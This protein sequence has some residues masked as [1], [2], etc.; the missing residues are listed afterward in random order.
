MDI[1]ICG[2]GDVGSHAAEALG[3]A[4]HSITLIDVDPRRLQAIE[5]TLDVRTLVG[6]CAE[7][8]VLLEADVSRADLLVAATDLD[9]VNL[10]TASIAKGLGARKTIARV[11]HSAFFEQRGM[12]YQAHF[13]VDRLI[14]PEY[15][16]ALSIARRLRNPVAMLIEDFARGAVEMQQFPVSKRSSAIGRSLVQIPLPPGSRLAAVQRKGGTFIPD[17]STTIEEGDSVILVANS[18]IFQDARR[19]FHKDDLGRRRVVIMGGGP[20]VV[21]L[22]RALRD[23]NFSIRLFELDGP[24]A[25]ELAEKLPWV[26]VI[27]ADPIVKAVFDEERLAQADV[28]VPLLGDD[29]SN[30]VACVVAKMRGTAEVITVVERAHYL[31]VIYDVAIDGAFSPRRVAAEEI[32]AVLDDSPL[33]FLG[34]IQ[35]GKVD[36]YQVRVGDHAPVVG[37]RLRDVKLSPDWVVAAIQ[38]GTTAKVPAPDD[39]FEPDCVLLAVGRHGREDVLRKVFAAK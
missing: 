33:R 5:E 3:A 17:G 13:G 4:G 1:I 15:S 21:W 37:E 12:N 9:E 14:C 20:M 26:T 6:N 30:I 10:L 25:R 23:R 27:Q 36:L 8:T 11:H 7:A 29:E 2:S 31:D 24:R 19:L 39:V 38:S 22:S 16:T 28:F 18:S 35:E 32:E 34:A